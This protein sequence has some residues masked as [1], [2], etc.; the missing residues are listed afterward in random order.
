MLKKF[1]LNFLSSFVGAWV[2]LGLFCFTIVLVVISLAGKAALSGGSVETVKKHSVMTLSLEGIIEEREV[3]ADFDYMNL[4]QGNLDRPMSLETLIKSIKGAAENKDIDMIYIKCKNFSAGPAT[5]HSLRKELLEFKKS[6]KKIYAYGDS[7]SN[8][9]YYI[10]SIADS[11]FINPQGSVSLQGLG[12]TSLYLKD[13][14]DKLGIEFTVVKVGEFKSAVEPFI[15]NRMSEPARAQLDTLFGNMWN[16][17]TEEIGKSRKLS[18]EEINRL[19]NQDNIMLQD[20]RYAE[21]TKLVDKAS[22]ERTMDSRIAAAI[23]VDKEKINYVSPQTVAENVMSISEFAAKE[24]IAVLYA[25][26]EIA[27]GTKTGINCEDLVP[28][29]TSLAED[30]NVKGLILRVNSPGGSVFGSEQIGEALNYFKSKDKPFAVSMGDYA[31]SGGYWISCQAD[32]IFADPLTI[33]GS[34][35]IYGLFPNITGLCEKL[36]VSPQE[37]YTNPDAVFPSLFS[38]MTYEQTS[39]MQTYVE[40]GYNQFVKRVA[41]GRN[42]KESKVRLIAEGRVWDGAKALKIGLVDE[43]GDLGSACEW[44]KSNIENGDKLPI[45]SYPQLEPGFWDLIHAA[46]QNAMSRAITERFKNLIPDTEVCEI[47]VR[48]LERKP[49]QARMQEFRVRM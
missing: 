42:L 46:G 12:S 14:F 45:V 3:P 43:L 32:R 1:F 37:V 13:L 41:I 49:V 44:M 2:A 31:A 6:G 4:L 18:P 10:A 29:I 39:A 5:L 28:V 23:G 27:E 20:G 7:Y 11:I 19:I 15:S 30:E 17:L 33:T 36:G 35:G 22:Y 34:I 40:K 38:R 9:S 47:A 26:G 24:R 48:I 25:T 8:G 16:L 21:N